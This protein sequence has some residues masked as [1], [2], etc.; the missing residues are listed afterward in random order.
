MADDLRFGPLDSHCA[1]L[2][3]NMERMFAEPT[4][5]RVKWLP[6]FCPRVREI[7]ALH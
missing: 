1:H 7:A 5:W 6:E 3:V 4:P 2:C